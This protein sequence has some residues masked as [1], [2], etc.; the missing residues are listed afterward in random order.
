[1]APVAERRQLRK[2]LLPPGQVGANLISQL[3]QSLLGVRSVMTENGAILEETLADL[4]SLE[5]QYRG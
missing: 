3:E 1:M 4:M 5:N 2:S